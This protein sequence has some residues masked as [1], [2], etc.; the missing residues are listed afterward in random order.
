MQFE[1]MELMLN[2]KFS[3]FGIA[4]AAV[5]AISVGCKPT[6]E[7]TPDPDNGGNGN[8]ST[9]IVRPLPEAQGNTANGDTIKIGL[10]AS[11]NGDLRPWGID[12][13]NG[14]LLA[15][16]EANANRA[17]GEAE[18]E[19]IIGDSNSKPEEGK[20]AA[21]NLIDEGV[22]G[23]VGEVSSGITAQLA[24]VAW[25]RGV[26]LVAVGATKPDITHDRG[27]VFR[28]CYTDD[29]QGPVMATFAYNDLGL[30]NVAIVTDIKQPYSQGLTETFR[31]KFLALGGTIADE[32]NYNTKDTQFNAIIANLKETSPD[33]IFLSGYFNEVGPFVAQARAQG[34]D[35]SV[36][37]MGGDGW[38]SAEILTSGGDAIVGGYF[39]NHYN[40]KEDREAVKTF[41]SKWDETYG[42]VPGT[43]MGA[44]G[45]DAVGLM[46]DA[47][48]RADEKSSPSII[49]ALENTTGYL[50]VSGTIDL[51]GMGGNPLKRAIVVELRPEGQMFAK[52]YEGSDVV[53]DA[54]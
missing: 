52:A 38:D 14:A 33:G 23:L 27:N 9:A 29:L 41:L 3:L 49:D 6:D 46:I 7:P 19:L 42:G 24:T 17:E 44:L 13:I 11:R 36:P 30:R 12:S 48:R 21:A 47:V 45:Y 25:E 53:G 28:V 2:K 8:Q 1:V 31:K 4:A 20:N 54:E 15:V 5:L 18:I 10:I 35:K 34:I 26:P 40:N 51:K 43:T 16:A 39:C 50:G 32:Q 22:V 37:V